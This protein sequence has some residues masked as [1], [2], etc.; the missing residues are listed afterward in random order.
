MKLIIIEKNKA[1]LN[2]FIDW[3]INV[4]GYSIILVLVSLIF[5]KTVQ[6]DLS[7]YGIWILVTSIIVYLLNKTVKPIIVWLTLPITGITMGLFYPFINVIILYITDFILL[8]HFN[9]DG[10]LMALVV[11]VFISIM[12]ILMDINLKLLKVYFVLTLINT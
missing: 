11:A 5:K 4:I 2:L 8:D 7:Y 1:R 3:L 12:N 10:I 6:F 9:M